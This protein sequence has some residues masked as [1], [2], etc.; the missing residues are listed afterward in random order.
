MRTQILPP[1]ERDR[2]MEGLPSIF[3]PVSR[4]FRPLLGYLLRAL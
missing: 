4:L 2:E 3:L 1:N